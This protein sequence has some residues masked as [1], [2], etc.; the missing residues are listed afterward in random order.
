MLVLILFINKIFIGVVEKFREKS[1]K[2]FGFCIFL[3][4]V[5]GL[6]VLNFRVVLCS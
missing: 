6:D 3:G 1:W 4:V 2:V 5:I